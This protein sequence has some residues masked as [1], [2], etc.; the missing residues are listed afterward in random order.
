MFL[1]SQGSPIRKIDRQ[2]GEAWMLFIGSRVELGVWGRI[3]VD[4]APVSFLHYRIRTE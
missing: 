1:C 3:S 2:A 4:G